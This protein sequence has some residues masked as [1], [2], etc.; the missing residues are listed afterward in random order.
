MGSKR[1]MKPKWSQLDYDSCFG[2]CCSVHLHAS[3][4]VGVKHY[5]SGW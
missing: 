1:E 2:L 3:V 4:Q 5:T